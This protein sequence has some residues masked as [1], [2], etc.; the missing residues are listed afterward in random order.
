MTM[1]TAVKPEKL[2]PLPVGAQSLVIG[3]VGRRGSGKSLVAAW[4]AY[5]RHRA[6]GKVLFT[7]SGFLRFGT[8]LDLEELVTLDEELQGALVVLDEVHLLL[9]RRNTMSFASRMLST[10]LVQ[11]RKR[12]CSVIW[13]TQS[14]RD[15]DRRLEFQ[16]D[17]HGHCESFRDGKTVTV[18]FVDTQ[19]R[20]SPGIDRVPS[21][22]WDSARKRQYRILRRADSVWPLFDTLAVGDLADILGLTRERITDALHGSADTVGEDAVISLIYELSTAGKSA[23]QPGEMSGLLRRQG[24][25]A[26]PPQ[27]GALLGTLGLEKTRTKLGA[28]YL[29]PEPGDL[30][31]WRQSLVAS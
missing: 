18:E 9:D 26:K 8:P 14:G 20:W 16:T 2:T 24:I 7:P 27:V 30:D 19:G 31:A 21:R 12:R 15:I 6:G 11:V 29:L 17:V 3:L 23:V 10:W 13:T 1:A 5:E 28:S 22:Y 25:E 4:L